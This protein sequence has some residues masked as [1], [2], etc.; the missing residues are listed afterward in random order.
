M[1]WNTLSREMVEPPL[2]EVSEK[3]VEASQYNIF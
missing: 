2:L 1:H 3:R